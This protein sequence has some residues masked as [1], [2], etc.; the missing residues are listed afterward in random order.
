[1]YFKLLSSDI[2][3]TASQSHVVICNEISMSSILLVSLKPSL[4]GSYR[5]LFDGFNSVSV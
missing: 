1:M 3:N 2:D 4:A 5:F